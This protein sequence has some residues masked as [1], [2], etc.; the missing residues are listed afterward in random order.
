M[1]LPRK[2]ERHIVEMIQEN[3]RPANEITDAT[4]ALVLVQKEVQFTASS[5]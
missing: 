3:I 4:V 5:V 2:R 1:I